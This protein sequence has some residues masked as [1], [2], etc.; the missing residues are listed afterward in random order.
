MNILADLKNII[1]RIFFI[2]WLSIIITGIIFLSLNCMS[3]EEREAIY[4]SNTPIIEATFAKNKIIS[5][6]TWK[7]YINASDQDGDMKALACNIY[8]D[9]IYT[10][11]LDIIKI[12]EDQKKKLSGY[13]YLATE[14]FQNLWGVN[15]E[16]HLNIFDYAGHWSDTTI[17]KMKFGSRKS[18]KEADKNLFTERSLGAILIKLV[19]PSVYDAGRS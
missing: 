17:I 18:K 14:A 9:G 16:L 7:I 5:G 11:P 12:K 8:Q 10:H 2:Q 15:V 19:N 6:D 4:G 3:L 1:S 13:I